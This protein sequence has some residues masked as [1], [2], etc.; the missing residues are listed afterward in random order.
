MASELSAANQFVRSALSA[1]ILA[2]GEVAMAYPR[3]AP[4]TAAPPYVIFSAVATRSRLGS[5]ARHIHSEITFLVRAI[6]RGDETSLYDLSALASAID[7]GL[8]TAAA[9]TIDGWRVAG[10]WRDP[11]GPIEDDDIE[12]GVRYVSRGAYY[13][14]H[15]YPSP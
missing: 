2:A 5:G 8:T 6:G 4:A 12:S 14:L 9:Q 7:D 3:L 10:C 15:V 11:R 1:G 13:T